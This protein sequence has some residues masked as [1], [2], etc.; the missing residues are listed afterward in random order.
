ME[1]TENTE[2]AE[3]LIEQNKQMFNA[4]KM[5]LGFLLLFE[6]IYIPSDE[7][8]MNYRSYSQTLKEHMVNIIET[9]P[10]YKA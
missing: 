5:A 10:Q 3:L 1:Q 9:M 2:N 6:D 4:C 7:E 8:E